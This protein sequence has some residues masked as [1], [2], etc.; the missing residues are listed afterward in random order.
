MQ[1]K[2]DIQPHGENSESKSKFTVVPFPPEWVDI[3]DILPNG[4]VF[5]DELRK[6]LIDN[7]LKADSIKK[8][9]KHNEIFKDKNMPFSFVIVGDDDNNIKAYAVY[10][11]KMGEG[12]FGGVKLVLDLQTNKW[13]AMKVMSEA[14]TQSQ[15]PNEELNKNSVVVPGSAVFSGTFVMDENVVDAPSFVGGGGATKESKEYDILRVLGEAKGQFDRTSPSK[16]N[17]HQTCYIMDLARGVPLDHVHNLEGEECLEIIVAVLKAF[18]KLNHERGILHRDIKTENMIYDKRKLGSDEAVHIIDYG[19]AINP[20]E[21]T[22]YV[23]GVPQGTPGWAAPEINKFLQYGMMIG[24]IP[25]LVETITRQDEYGTA[26]KQ[27]H[28]D[29]R[30]DVSEE[31]K[32]TL[33]AELNS[34][35]ADY[36]SKSKKIGELSGNRIRKQLKILNE[37]LPK[38]AINELKAMEESEERRE[39]IKSHLANYQAELRANSDHVKEQIAIIAIKDPEKKDEQYYNI[40]NE[41]LTSTYKETSDDLAD[42]LKNLEEINNS[43]DSLDEQVAELLKRNVDKQSLGV[44]SPLVKRFIKDFDYFSQKDLESK[45]SALEK[46][47]TQLEEESSKQLKT[48]QDNLK[49]QVDEMATRDGE[50]AQ[51]PAMKEGEVIYGP[52]SETYSIAA[53]VLA[54][55]KQTTDID[56]RNQIL[57][58]FFETN[59]WKTPVARPKYGVMLQYFEDI[60]AAKKLAAKKLAGNADQKKNTEIYLIDCAHLLN[61]DNGIDV[62]KLNE[63]IV[64]LTNLQ[65]KQVM[66]VGNKNL[67]F[68]IYVELRKALEDK[69]IKVNLDIVL[70]NAEVTGSEIVAMA[71]QIDSESKKQVISQLENEIKLLDSKKEKL[72]S[73]QESIKSEKNKIDPKKDAAKRE[74]ESNDIIEQ[75]R[76][77]I[78]DLENKIAQLKSMISDEKLAD[79]NPE[80]LGQ[81]EKEV[82]G[83]NIPLKIQQKQ[84]DLAKKVLENLNTFKKEQEDLIDELQKK[85]DKFP[86]AIENIET[87]IANTRKKIADIDIEKQQTRFVYYQHKPLL[88]RREI[89]L[90]AD[91]LQRKGK[92]PVPAK[93]IVHDMRVEEKEP[94]E[95]PSKPVIRVK[96]M[97]V[98]SDVLNTRKKPPV[99]VSRDLR[100]KINAML[101]NR[102]FASSKQISIKKLEALNKEDRTLTEDELVKSLN[103]IILETARKHK[104]FL[105]PRGSK[106]LVAIL[107]T[108]DQGLLLKL[109]Y[110]NRIALQKYSKNVI[111]R[112]FTRAQND[113][114]FDQNPNAETGLK[115]KGQ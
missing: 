56:M 2:Q 19:L 22:S 3:N 9:S 66:L 49:E 5:D 26:I 32:D 79:N 94:P 16:D 33:L 88:K 107:G 29:P 28:K 8:Y 78:I 27:I 68:K 46:L 72:M 96:P 98:S 41:V 4:H 23:T 95:P 53:V 84:V 55:L 42:M 7:Y 99:P 64:D 65:A 70:K 111:M 109:S 59:N 86:K 1:H 73:V 103:E 44:R 48:D 51:A 34:K 108:F 50:I 61:V 62:Q 102:T 36:E 67:S 20:Q 81:I 106:K 21:N 112:F 91:V 15:K 76:Q 43:T 57:E 83:L 80:K 6:S 35:V 47:S 87:Q 25:D 30:E 12:A 10:E 101:S 115:H 45:I 18:N 52:S 31:F 38:E 75:Y 74:K 90:T 100:I 63:I 110:E 82:N 93:P 77:P 71:K 11:G 40:L 17:A 58:E 113:G 14:N 97:Q 54:L 24:S 105:N 37:Y 89:L 13:E 60:L 114:N 39:L 92:A 69:G 104:R 85:L